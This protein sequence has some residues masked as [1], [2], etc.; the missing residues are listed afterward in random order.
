MQGYIFGEQGLSGSSFLKMDYV[1][2]FGVK[3]QTVNVVG[4]FHQLENY[5][6]KLIPHRP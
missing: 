2:I 6:Q 3:D 4:I 1:V 5:P